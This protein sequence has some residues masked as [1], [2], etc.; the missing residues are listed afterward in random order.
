LAYFEHEQATVEGAYR[1]KTWQTVA[2]GSYAKWCLQGAN[3]GV[4]FFDRSDR[5]LITVK[6]AFRWEWLREY[7]V[8]RYGDLE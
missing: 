3:D 2:N 6:Q 1:L 4:E 7:F 8:T 5:Q